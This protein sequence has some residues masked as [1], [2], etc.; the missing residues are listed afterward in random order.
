VT[1]G[2]GILGFGFIGRI[3]AGA[4][5]ADPR[6][7]LV[8]IADTDPACLERVATD[9][10]LDRVRRYGT[11][12]DLLTSPGVDAVVLAVPTPMH[13]P[14]AAAA[15]DAGKHVL[16]EKPLALRGDDARP[17]VAAAARH[18]DLVCQPAH[19]MRFWPGWNWLRDAVASRA[20]GPVLSATFARVG[21]EPGWAQHFYGDPIASGSAILDLHIHDADFVRHCFGDPAS[22]EAVGAVGSS[23]GIHH[24]L[25]RYRFDDGPALVTAEGGWLPGRV[26]FEMHFRVSFAKAVAEFRLGAEPALAVYR[27]S[28]DPEPI[29]IP[30]GDG[31][32]Y[33]AAHFLDR[34]EGQ[35]VAPVVTLDDGVQAVRLIDAERASVAS[36]RAEPFRKLAQ[37]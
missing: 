36:G 18:P 6:A 12:D 24:V 16:V 7:R 1:I 3:H 32:R 26:P 22:V 11:A 33:Q 4:F 5:A 17:I 10:T 2:V 35:R 25:T 13:P 27:P 9:E 20:Y 37:G 28:G 14:L 30:P 21:S 15:L 31:Y 23:G 29:A 8:A 19:C 34:I